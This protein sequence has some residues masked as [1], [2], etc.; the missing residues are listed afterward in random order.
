MANPEKTGYTRRRQT[1]CVL[2]TT[3]RN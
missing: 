1:Q 2:G 3:M